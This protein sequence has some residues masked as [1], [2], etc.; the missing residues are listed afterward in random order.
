MP[1]PFAYKSFVPLPTLFCIPCHWVTMR[2]ESSGH[3]YDQKP[4]L[5]LTPLINGP[6]KAMVLVCLLSGNTRFVFF[7]NTILFSAIILDAFKLSELFHCCCSRSVLQ[8]L[9]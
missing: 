8:N 9:N 3:E 6:I 2:A 7:N 4:M 1:Q 5:S